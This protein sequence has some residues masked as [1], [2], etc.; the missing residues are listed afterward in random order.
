[1]DGFESKPA[2]E[3]LE[4]LKKFESTIADAC[5]LKGTLEKYRLTKLHHH[6]SPLERILQ[7]VYSKTLIDLKMGAN[8]TAFVRRHIEELEQ[9]VDREESVEKLRDQSARLAE[10]VKEAVN[11]L[12]DGDGFVSSKRKRER[13]IDALGKQAEDVLAACKKIKTGS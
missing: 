4:I 1:M 6:M 8:D 11:G 13:D 9:H 7:G 10:A 3:R 2:K 5:Q 12:E